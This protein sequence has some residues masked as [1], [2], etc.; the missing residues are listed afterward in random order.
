MSN[1]LDFIFRPHSV[2]VIGA[3]NDPLKWGNWVSRSLIDSSWKGTFYPVNSRTSEVCGFRA[4]PS[5]LD[6]DETIDIAVIGIPIRFVPDAVRDCIEKKVKAVIIISAG[7]A[8]TGED[9]K[10]VQDE[11]VEMARKAGTRIIGPNCAG[12]FNASVDLN[13]SVISFDKGPLALISQS[14]N[15]AVNINNFA[16]KRGLGFSKWISIGNQ[17]DVGFDEYLEYCKDDPDTRVILIYMEGL[18]NGRQFLRIAKETVKV[19]PIVLLKAGSSSAG[20]RSASSHTGALAGS[21]KV[22][23]G[24]FKQAGIIRVTDS[25]ELLDMGEAL[26]KCPLPKGNSVAIVSDGGGDA[27]MAADAAERNG[28][29]IPDLLPETQEK[30]LKLIPIG[31]VHSVKNPVDWASEADLWC[32]AK[33]TEVLLEED[34]IDGVIIAGGF[35]Q[36]EVNQPQFGTVEHEVADEIGKLENKYRKPIMVQTSAFWDNPRSLQILRA[37]GVPV[38]PTVEIETRYMRALI[39]YRQYLERFE[40][41]KAFGKPSYSKE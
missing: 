3:S 13:T 2:A 40:K 19:K 24:A 26:L 32:F 31:A 6:I 36:Y 7:F 38:Y 41:E 5:V 23:S 39:E 29:F 27:T 17:A 22:F 12:L 35:G 28:L 14:G 34:Y 1:N 33:L 37:Q 16:K 4:Y 15:F 8:E 10:K 11:I 9:G 25:N 21:D 20:I 18:K 30:L